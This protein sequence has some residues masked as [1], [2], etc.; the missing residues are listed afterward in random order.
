YPG[1]GGSY[2]VARANLGAGAGLLAGAA[3]MTDYVLNVAVGI[4]A[5]VGAI[6][7]AVPGLQPY[8]LTIC[9]AILVLLTVV[10][11]RGIGEA[12]VLFMLPTC[13]FV[14]SLFTLLVWG[15]YASI[16]SGG[17][18][19]ALVPPPHAPGA[20]V[21]AAGWW[22]LLRAFASGCTAMTGV[23]AVSNGVQA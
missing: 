17:H 9:L 13:L 20:T 12:G 7:S 1:G 5:G 15:T 10:N 2:T 14:L 8:T 6:I 18:P 21:A 23:E 11:L 22:I 4:S 3:L 19:H 16:S